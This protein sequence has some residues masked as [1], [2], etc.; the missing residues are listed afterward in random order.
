MKAYGIKR[1]DYGNWPNCP[2]CPD[3]YLSKGKRMNPRTKS[4]CRKSAK[5]KERRLNT[6]KTFDLPLDNR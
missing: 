4:I 1:Q 6:I 2:C 5:A 3:K